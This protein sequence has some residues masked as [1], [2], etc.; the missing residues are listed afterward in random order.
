M[1]WHCALLNAE[2]SHATVDNA[3]RICSVAHSGTNPTLWFDV[4]SV[5]TSQRHITIQNV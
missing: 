4:S 2:Q 3:T 1:A 5:D